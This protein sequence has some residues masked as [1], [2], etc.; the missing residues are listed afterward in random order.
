MAVV[1]QQLV[2]RTVIGDED[3]EVAVAIDITE[4]DVSAWLRCSERDREEGKM[5]SA[6]VE[7]QLVGR[8]VI[9]DEDIEVAVAIDITAMSVLGCGAPRGMGGRENW[10]VPSLSSSWLD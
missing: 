9:G 4:C 3:I 6:V 10:P 8:T 7:Q 1:E 2:G 5:A